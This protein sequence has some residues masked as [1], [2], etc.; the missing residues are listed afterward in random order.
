MKYVNLWPRPYQKPHP[1]IWIPSQG[2]KET[3]DWASHPD[4]R[5]TYLQTFSPAK[6]VARYLKMYRDTCQGHGY[7][8]Q[9]FT[10]RL[11]RPG[12]RGRRR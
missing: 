11:G 8:G 6:V 10:T 1:P 3:I 7:A 4:R 12:L 2:S 9:G 5:Y